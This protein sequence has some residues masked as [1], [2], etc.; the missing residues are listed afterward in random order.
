MSRALF[1]VSACL[2]GKPCRYDGLSKAR[3]S[4]VQLARESRCVFVCP[5]VMG[6]L[7]IPRCPCEIR[8]NAVISSEGRDCT[9]EYELGARLSLEAAEREGCRIAV[10]KARSP[11]CGAGRVYDGS[12]THT[13]RDRGWRLRGPS[14]EQGIHHFYGRE[15]PRSCAS[16]RYWAFEQNV[17]RVAR[18]S[19]FCIKGNPLVWRRCL[20]AG[21]DR[22]LIFYAYQE[23]Y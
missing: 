18:F 14:P 16:A 1:V 22:L 10:L 17:A 13:L 21:T 7:P 6:G 12:F 8:E 15:F 3:E 5:E 9:R 23:G 4:I 2:V 19:C 11:S 20:P